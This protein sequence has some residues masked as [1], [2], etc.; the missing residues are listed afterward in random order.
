[1]MRV[2]LLVNRIVRQTPTHTSLHLAFEAARRGHQVWYLAVD[3]FS[4]DASGRVYGATV[5]VP[6]V[7]ARADD[8]ATRAAFAAGLV[9]RA[10]T[11]PFERLDLA[12]LDVLFL[13]NNP[14]DIEEGPDA[15]AG[16]PALAFGRKLRAAGVLVANDPDGIAR[17]ASKMT[18]LAD[19]PQVSQPRTLVAK[20]PD[21]LRGFLDELGAPAVVKPLTGYGGADVFYLAPGDPNRNA[22]LATVTRRGYA[23]AQEF[24][25]EARD[26]DRRLLLLDGEPLVVDGRAAIY[27]R[28]RPADDLRANLH[29]GGTGAPATFTDADAQ[30]VAPLRDRLR[31]EG[32]YFVGVDLLGSRVLELNVHAPGGIHNVNLFQGINAG[33]HVIG[34]L[35]RRVRER[36]S[37]GGR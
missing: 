27:A 29:V 18:L 3:G 28:K 31:Q 34:D 6:P 7:S 22:V 15:V 10:E 35:E 16:N 12:T 26:G 5:P 20:R 4:L 24:L 9:E 30:A 21:E 23:V 33:A 19:F 2:G 13:R 14:A 1:M 37:G 8:D 11:G 17:A 32:L 36:R 25:P